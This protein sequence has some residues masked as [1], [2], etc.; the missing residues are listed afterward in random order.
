MISRYRPRDTT[1]EEIINGFAGRRTRTTDT[2][3]GHVVLRLR[4]I[5][6]KSA[7][8]LAA[9]DKR[10][11]RDRTRDDAIITYGNITRIHGLLP[12]IL[13]RCAPA[14]LR[15]PWRTDRCFRSRERMRER[16]CEV[17]VSSCESIERASLT[18]DASGRLRDIRVIAKSPRRMTRAYA[19]RTLDDVGLS[20]SLTAVSVFVDAA[21]TRTAN[22][23]RTWLT[24]CQALTHGRHT[25][26]SCSR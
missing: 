4:L 14:L 2:T 16:R 15:H 5:I 12:R 20:V 13:S 6:Q 8:P 1:D 26:D 18:A 17:S 24:P 25:G 11:R 7:G 19:S 3:I 10:T 22:R 9:Q 21:G 23:S